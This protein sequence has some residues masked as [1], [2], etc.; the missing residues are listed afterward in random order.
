MSSTFHYGDTFNYTLNGIAHEIPLLSHIQIQQK[1]LD[2]KLLISQKFLLKYIHDLFEVHSID[3]FLIQHSLLGYYVF[4]GIHIFYPSIQICINEHHKQKLQKRKDEILSDH[5][6]FDEFDDHFIISSSFFS[7]SNVQAFIYILKTDPDH[8]QE[9]S[10]SI[11][12]EK[13]HHKLYD[14]YPLQK[15]KYEE[16]EVF[17]PHKINTVLENYHF[18]LQFIQFKENDSK[19]EI[20][21]E[22]ERQRLHQTIH[23]SILQP[24]LQLKN[25]IF[26]SST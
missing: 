20:I 6:D 18:H 5:F 2:D 14:I 25:K 16:F 19:R 22:E 8:P 24:L 12:H 1:P 26:T 10:H 4:Q 23:D 3:Y 17:I 7:K 21:E 13:Y 11:Q 15:V 9:L